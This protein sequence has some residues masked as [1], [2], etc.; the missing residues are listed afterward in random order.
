MESNANNQNKTEEKPSKINKLYCKS[1]RGILRLAIIVSRFENRY[2]FINTLK[3]LDFVNTR[4]DI[5]RCRKHFKY[6]NYLCW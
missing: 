4:M 3:I 5:S 6:H 2:L 1:F